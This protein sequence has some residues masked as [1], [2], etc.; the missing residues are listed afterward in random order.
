M[1]KL[2][3][4]FWLVL[5]TASGLAMFAVKYQV[6]SLDDRLGDTKKAV[7][8]Q[9]R[10]LRVLGAEWAY[11]NRPAALAD[12]NRRFLSLTPIAT[13]QLQT[14][15]ADI[16]MRPPPPPEPEPAPPPV[17]AAATPAPD[18]AAAAP[19]SGARLPG[20]GL[21]VTP[22][23]LEK[24]GREPAAPPAKSLDELIARIAAVR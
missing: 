16:A 12:M 18:T 2:A 10:E 8:A 20:S 11:L 6:Q 13:K 9:E 24:P 7:A 4:L 21:P 22:A 19:L 3:T 1:I 14:G 15:V 5:V 23:S 17:V